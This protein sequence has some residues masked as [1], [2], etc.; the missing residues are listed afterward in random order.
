MAG[1][2][3]KNNN[4]NAIGAGVTGAG[5]GTFIVM[6]ANSFPEGSQA[7]E[8]LTLVAPSLTIAIGAIASV[9]LAKM[10]QHLENRDIEKA[11]SVA[12]TS[13]SQSLKN[14]ETSTEHKNNLR[15]SLEQL[16][17]I[18]LESK[19][20]NVKNLIKVSTTNKNN[21]NKPFKQGK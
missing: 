5:G 20:S 12:K 16:E 10:I 19:M 21:P 4:K 18:D 13:F 2:K 3:E 11:L 6:L 17:L 9:C 1:A 8:I 14:P 7:Q 15:K